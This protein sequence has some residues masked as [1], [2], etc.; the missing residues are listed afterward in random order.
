MKNETFHFQKDKMMLWKAE[1]LPV[2]WLSPAF[3]TALVVLRYQRNCASFHPIR[4]ISHRQCKNMPFNP[5]PD[6]TDTVLIDEFFFL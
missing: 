6:Y 3:L 1:E 4:F 5:K 2:G